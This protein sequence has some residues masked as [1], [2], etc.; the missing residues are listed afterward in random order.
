MQLPLGSQETEQRRKCPLPSG[1][2]HISSP[3]GDGGP[4]LSLCQAYLF[5]YPCQAGRSF[6][7]SP[8][9]S[10]GHPMGDRLSTH[11]GLGAAEILLVLA[12]LC[13]ECSRISPHVLPF[14]GAGCTSHFRTRHARVLPLLFVLGRFDCGCCKF[15]RCTLRATPMVSWLRCTCRPTPMVSWL[16][17]MRRPAPMA[18]WFLKV[19]A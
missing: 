11:A 6:S 4:D 19:H 3:A 17:C 13:G 9:R 10:A 15:V 2:Q 8:L 14:P 18:S 7:K 5:P 16:R 12:G 1:L